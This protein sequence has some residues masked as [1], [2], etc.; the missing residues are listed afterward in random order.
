M[1]KYS[2]KYFPQYV[3]EGYA[4]AVEASLQRGVLSYEKEFI[5][6]EDFILGAAEWDT[7]YEP[8]AVPRAGVKEY[9]FFFHRMVG[10]RYSRTFGVLSC[11]VNGKS[12]VDLVIGPQYRAEKVLQILDYYQIPWTEGEFIYNN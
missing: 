8:V 7:S 9:V 11:R 12:I 5:L 4:A 3:Q 10:G 1:L 6:T 2:T